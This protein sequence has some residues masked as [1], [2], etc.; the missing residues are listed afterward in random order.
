MSIESELGRLIRAKGEIEEAI[1]NKGVN[2]PDDK[3][4]D[5]YDSY[6]NMISGSEGSISI[7]WGLLTGD[8]HDQEDLMQLIGEVA[9]NI[10]TISD[11]DIDNIFETDEE[12]A[13]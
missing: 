4:L 6:I 5:W 10:E 11:G 8:I 9:N 2:V 3:R 13:L 7:E 12:E 1:E